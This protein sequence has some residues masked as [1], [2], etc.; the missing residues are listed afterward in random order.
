MDHNEIGI[1]HSRPLPGLWGDFSDEDNARPVATEWGAVG[2]E[3]APPAARRG[4]AL[5]NDRWPH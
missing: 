4:Q 5:I 3:P 1:G 2:V